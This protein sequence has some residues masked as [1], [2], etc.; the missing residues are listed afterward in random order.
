MGREVRNHIWGEGLLAYSPTEK[1][2]EEA[3]QYLTEEFELGMIVRIVVNQGSFLTPHMI[4]F[5]IEMANKAGRAGS[6]LH[7]QLCPKLL[8]TLEKVPGA[9]AMVLEPTPQRV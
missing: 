7:L 3:R 5:F 9:T 4:L 8:E 6:H 1:D 2:F